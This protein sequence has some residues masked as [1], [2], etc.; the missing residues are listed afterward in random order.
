MYPCIGNYTY[1]DDYM[2]LKCIGRN[3]NAADR[4][5][6]CKVRPVTTPAPTDAP[7]VV[8]ETTSEVPTLA[9]SEGVATTTTIPGGPDDFAA[10]TT[11]TAE[12][13]KKEDDEEQGGSHRSGGQLLVVLLLSAVLLVETS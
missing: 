2:S 6:C 7:A 8:A 11:T 5:I 3:C 13:D 10:P 4:D 9:A 12:A 1:K